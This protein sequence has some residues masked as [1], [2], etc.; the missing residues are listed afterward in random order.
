MDGVVREWKA[1]IKNASV[2]LNERDWRQS[3]TINLLL[4]DDAAVLYADCK[5]NFQQKVIWNVNDEVNN[6]TEGECGK[7]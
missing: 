3:G 7:E 1:K 5:E 2:F 6:K 4:H